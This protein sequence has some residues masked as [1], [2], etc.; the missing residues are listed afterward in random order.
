MLFETYVPVEQ[1]MIVT[2]IMT[3]FSMFTRFWWT[4]THLQSKPSSNFALRHRLPKLV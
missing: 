2:V 1:E 3:A 4:P